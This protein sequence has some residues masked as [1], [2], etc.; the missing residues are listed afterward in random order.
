MA[1]KLPEGKPFAAALTVMLV[2]G[3]IGFVIAELIP[4]GPGRSPE[5]E[6]PGPARGNV[7]TAT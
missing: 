7:T 6:A 4:P 3:V 1:A 2:F 5:E